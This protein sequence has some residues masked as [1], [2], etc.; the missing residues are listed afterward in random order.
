MDNKKEVSKP[1]DGYTGK[2]IDIADLVDIAHLVSLEQLKTEIEDYQ[3]LLIQDMLKLGY[4]KAGSYMK[5][6]VTTLGVITFRVVRLRKPD[7]SG[8]I[9][10]ILDAFHIRNQ[11]YTR[12]VRMLCVDMASKMSYN[13]ASEEIKRTNK[14]HVPKRTIHSFV[15]EIGPKLKKVNSMITAG[16]EKPKI[17]MGDGTEVRSIYKMPN[18]VRVIIGAD[19]RSLFDVR[20]NVPWDLMYRPDGNYVLVSD[21][22]RSLVD[23]LQSN[24][25]LVQLDL[26]HAIRQSMFK[27]WGEGMSKAQRDHISSELNRILFTLVNSVKKHMKDGNVEALDDRIKAAMKELNLLADKL[28]SLNFYGAAEFIRKNSVLMVT[29]ARLAVQGRNI[30]YTSNMIERVMGEVSKRCKHKW[31]HWSMKG[32]ENILDIV[33]I[34]YMRNDIYELFYNAYIHPSSNPWCP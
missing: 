3:E 16:E 7:G 11:K 24:A 22:E 30:P 26:V 28:A 4:R 25:E 21:D 6:I 20:V 34:R 1:M 27:L 13:D 23:G 31:A 5:T 8:T 33:L 12:D 17:I 2:D 19:Q 14:I 29:F 32:L 18:E 15:Q 10:P 9:S